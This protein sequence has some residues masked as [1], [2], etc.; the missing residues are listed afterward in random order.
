MHLKGK[1]GVR[2][3]QIQFKMKLKAKSSP[4]YRF[5]LAAVL[6]GCISGASAGAYLALTHDLPQIKFL[7]SYQPSAITRIYSSDQ[8]LLD[9]I[10]I[11]KRDP[12]TL[13]A[14]PPML[15]KALLA[16]EDR[17]FYQHRGIALKGILRA[18]A[19]NLK[20]GRFAQGAS[21]LTQQL[22][23]TLFLTPRKTLTRK[24][25][26]AILALQLERRYTKNEILT[27]Y[28]NQVYFGS[29]AWGVASAARIF[30]A[31]PLAKLTL[32]ECAL[33]AGMPKA[34]SAYSPLVNPELA[35]KRR[36]LVLKQMYDLHLIDAAAYQQAIAEPLHLA[37]KGNQDLKAP[38]FVNFVRQELERQLGHSR[39]Y[40][41]GLTVETTL[42]W[43]LQQA[44]E[45][46]V[47]TGLDNIAARMQRKGL[48]TDK[49]QAA[50]VALDVRSGAI[51]A[52]VG[53]RNNDQSGFNRAWEAR[54]QPGSA[55]KPIVYAL[56]I[57]KG[58][59]QTYHIL[60]APVAFKNPSGTDWLPQNFSRSYEGEITLRHALAHSKNIPAV[61]LVEK[62]GPAAVAQFAYKL[63]I[64]PGL[65]EDLSLAL[66]TSEV[67]LLN[68]TAAYATFANGGLY[69]RPYGIVRIMDRQGRT[70]WSNKYER[71][72]AMSP[73]AA[74]I[75]T[76]MLQAVVNEG[77]ARA[78]RGLGPMVAGK[79]G[80]TD[81]YCDALFVGYSPRIAA[82]VWVGN[83]NHTTLGRGE[84]G[85]RAALPIWIRFMESIPPPDKPEYFDLPDGIKVLETDNSRTATGQTIPVLIRKGRT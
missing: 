19:A 83:D 3:C 36:N 68:L 43:K 15:V 48:A 16:T 80:T 66:G 5:V 44:A 28:L 23:K 10:Y 24:L 30:F 11:E 63:G 56:A 71:H 64:A 85:S 34:P 18:L 81:D 47:A 65:R 84:T 69:T 20:T 29:G 55:F 59:S 58:F 40:K 4:V 2:L 6:L 38:F 61:R 35:I 45:K 27:L 31:K 21:T 79:T 77:T 13:K 22:A 37:A 33:I 1:A 46:A 49:L 62:L 51:L 26:E 78:A 42:D 74:A 8:R 7:E 67:C 70:I 60:D 72:L 50:L 57:E 12:V 82:G 76:N 17:R 75:T 14:V 52:M 25:K 41:A 9:E 54:R 53:G 73:Q 39:L 32:A